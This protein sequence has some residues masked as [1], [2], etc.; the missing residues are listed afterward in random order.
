MSL[1]FDTQRDPR[2]SCHERTQWSLETGW[3]LKNNCQLSPVTN[4]LT[5]SGAHAEF[6]RPRP[7]Q[8]VTGPIATST[9]RLSLETAAWDRDKGDSN[10]RSRD[11]YPF[12]CHEDHAALLGR[13]RRSLSKAI[14]AAREACHHP[15]PTIRSHRL[16]NKQ[17]QNDDKKEC[18]TEFSATD[19]HGIQRSLPGCT[20]KT[21]IGIPVIRTPTPLVMFRLSLHNI[22]YRT[23][24]S[25]SH[26]GAKSLLNWT[27]PSLFP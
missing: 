19:R 6:A 8:A 9:K 21:S 23:Q 5:P 11:K 4:A 3:P 20:Q 27:V 10:L 2:S 22:C 17:R 16:R 12:S 7:G 14:Q 18:I 25:F 1:W 15:G 26:G 13:D 24:S